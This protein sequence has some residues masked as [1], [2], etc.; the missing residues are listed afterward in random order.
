MLVDETART[1][2]GGIEAG[3]LT[4]AVALPPI[5]EAGLPE[6][7]ARIAPAVISGDVILAIAV[8]EPSGGPTSR[9]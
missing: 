8:T 2:A 5:I 4:H 9:N 3:L 7:R 1:G 6:L